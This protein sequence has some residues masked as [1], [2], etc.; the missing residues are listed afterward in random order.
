MY[1]KN[2]ILYNSNLYCLKY[3]VGNLNY[4]YGLWNLKY[5]LKN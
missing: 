3:E 5:E 1:V 4:I 2:K